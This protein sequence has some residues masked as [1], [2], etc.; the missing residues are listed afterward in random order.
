MKFGGSS[1][2][3]THETFKGSS[4]FQGG[5]LVHAGLLPNMVRRVGLEPTSLAATA[6]KTAVYTIPPP[7]LL[8]INLFLFRFQHNHVHR[9]LLL[10]LLRLPLVHALANSR[11]R[12]AYHASLLHYE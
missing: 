6:S 5:V 4:R 8:K 7:A 1:E 9:Q 12:L 10:Q 11:H 2:N 3:R